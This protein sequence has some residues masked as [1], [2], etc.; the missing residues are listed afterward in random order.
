MTAAPVDD[1]L[2]EGRVLADKWRLEEQL[3][4][5]GM[6]TVW[7]ATH[8]NGRRVA[9]K[10]L[11]AALSAD[12]HLRDRFLREGYVANRIDHPGVVE[13][14]DDTVTDDGLVLLVME[15]LD[16][17][18]LKDRWNRAER[19][20]D[21]EEVVRIATEVLEILEAAHDAGVVHRDVKP[22]NIFMLETGAIKLLD[23][24]I[25]RLREVSGF[26]QRTTT[27]TMLGTPAFMPPEQALGHWDKVSAASDVFA[28]GAT[29]WT[30]MTGRLVHTAKTAQELVI[31]AGTE[32]ARPIA[33]TM[34][35]IPAGLC[36]I[37]DKALRF[38]SGERWRSASDMR[39]ALSADDLLDEAP[40]P[41]RAIP[42]V[43]PK[44]EEGAD[45]DSTRHGLANATSTTPESSWRRA[46]LY[47]SGAAV[48]LA[49]G[50]GAARLGDPPPAG[51]TAPTVADTTEPMIYA[52]GAPSTETA[53]EPA[54]TATPITAPAPST[55][56][57]A[58]T[59][60]PSISQS[61]PKRP[62]PKR[63]PKHPVFNEGIAAK[64]V[65]E[66]KA[67]AQQ[68]CMNAYPVSAA[69]EI[70]MSWNNTGSVSYA[71]HRGTPALG[72]C[73]AQVMFRA[74]V[75]AFSGKAPERKF[76]VSITK[77]RP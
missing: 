11:H 16:G 32:H 66:A 2:Y 41:S 45:P 60:A 19:K 1:R 40:A 69:T 6:A 55:A 27:G 36:A 62:A 71:F 67:A 23:F 49:A 54:R 18:T 7:G 72:A 42:L 8:R 10:V 12:A 48:M 34:A 73:V 28:V 24:G 35:D 14:L 9:V 64:K 3:G 77:P 46:A 22:D 61:D 33:M 51:S 52:S 44:T 76:V 31:A 13:V 47:V 29:M 68:I 75:P 38:D 56:A 17:E 5:G 20:M 53:T 50:F 39:E 43:E 30:L 21:V 65:W 58:G 70:R 59:A 4:H 37:V 63:A 25:A 74:T 57:P 15:R 26:E